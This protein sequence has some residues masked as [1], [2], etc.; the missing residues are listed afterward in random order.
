MNERTDE[1]EHDLYS[2]VFLSSLEGL[3]IANDTGKGKHPHKHT[4]KMHIVHI[5][6]HCCHSYSMDVVMTVRS[7]R[8]QQ[9]QQQ[10]QNNII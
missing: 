6:F 3:D 1:E 9:I 8:D 4:H 2:G 7:N 10:K 5:Y